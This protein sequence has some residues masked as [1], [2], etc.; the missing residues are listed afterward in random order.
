MLTV[1]VLN[2]KSEKVGSV[3]L[4]EEVFSVPV[5]L[6]VLHSVVQWQLAKRRQGTHMVKTRG[7]DLKNVFIAEKRGNC[8]P[9][10]GS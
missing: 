3:G 6:D 10:N 2:W 9:L 5:K 1:D 4:D 7:L 8:R